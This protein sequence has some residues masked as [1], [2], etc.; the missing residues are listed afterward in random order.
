MRILTTASAIL[1]ASALAMPAA[2]CDMHGGGGFFGQFN[3]ASW[4][5][6]TPPASESDLEDSASEWEKRN[7]SFTPLP[8]PKKPTFS[9][10]SSRASAAAKARLAAKAKLAALEVA[11]SAAEE[12]GASELSDTAPL[13]AGR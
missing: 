7:A 4:S 3:G 1:L 10:F 5:D 13:N 9:K 12:K 6:Y 11:E 8:K 2:A